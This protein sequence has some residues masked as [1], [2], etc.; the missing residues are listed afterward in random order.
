MT[1]EVQCC[2]ECWMTALHKGRLVPWV[3]FP[4]DF[5]SLKFRGGSCI[6]EW[7]LV[8]F[9]LHT[10]TEL[11]KWPQPLGYGQACADRELASSHCVFEPKVSIGVQI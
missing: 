9:S 7:E 11:G 5:P 6:L 3:E 4:W 2:A 1:C 8:S 10:L